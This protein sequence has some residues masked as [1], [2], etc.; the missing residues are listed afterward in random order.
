MTMTAS[1]KLTQI[2]SELRTEEAEIINDKMI[3]NMGPSHPATHGTVK[4]VLTLDGETVDDV[5]ITI[6]YL[7]RG[8]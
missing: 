2:R 6:G 1:Q 7:H 8:F 4:F 5:D 3:I